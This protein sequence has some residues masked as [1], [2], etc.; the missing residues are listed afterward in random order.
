M[1]RLPIQ[2]SPSYGLP[3]VPLLLLLLAVT[4]CAAQRG[5]VLEL[6]PFVAYRVGGEFSGF[7]V[8]DNASYGG[9]IGYDIGGQGF[10]PEFLFSHQNSDIVTSPG[11]VFRANININQWV[12]QGFRSFGPSRGRAVPFGTIGVALTDL[13]ASAGG[14]SS[15]RFAGVAGLGAKV[16][17]NP[18]VGFRFDARAYFTFVNSSGGFYCGTGGG[19]GVGY[20]GSVFFQMDLGGGVVIALGKRRPAQP[21]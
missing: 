3:L 7:S 15:T 10:G 13:S 8:K 2:P 20:S 6:T 9:S 14:G 18:S 19:C 16:F 11:G 5:G 1:R 4:P 17:A 21:R 12:L